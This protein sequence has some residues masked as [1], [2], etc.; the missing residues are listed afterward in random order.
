MRSFDNRRTLSRSEAR[1]VYDRFAE[2]GHA[3][4][5]DATS[6]YGG[7]AVLALLSLGGFSSV[8]SVL[9]YGCGQ[10]KLAEVVLSGSPNVKHWQGIDQSPN[11]VAKS[12]ERLDPFGKRS[13]VDLLEGGDPHDTLR[14]LR[15][16]SSPSV[17]ND[18]VPLSTRFDRFVSTYCLDL[19]SEPDLYAVLDVAQRALHPDRGLILLAGITQCRFSDV[20]RSPLVALTTLVWSVVYAMFPHIVGGCR[21]QN[22]EPYLEER[23][24]TVVNVTRTFPVGFP[25]MMSEVIAARP[26]SS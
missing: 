2:T 6:N 17:V 20:L 18:D 21:T 15:R 11:M 10:G 14:L 25:W 13:S 9:D 3:G 12:R 26:P 16:S 4:G 23:G 7:P 19:L 22:L 1:S 8:S 24:W 5:K